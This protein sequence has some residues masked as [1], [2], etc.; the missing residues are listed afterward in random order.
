MPAWF[1]VFFNIFIMCLAFTLSTSVLPNY[2]KFPVNLFT[3]E[4]GRANCIL[5][6]FACKMIMS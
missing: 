4:N 1:G 5:V 3:D 2:E 6:Y